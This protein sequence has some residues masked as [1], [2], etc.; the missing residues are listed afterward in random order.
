MRPKPRAFA[1]RAERSPWTLELRTVLAEA[2]RTGD[3]RPIDDLVRRF[4]ADDARRYSS[5][6]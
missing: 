2:E 3:R 5:L 1:E 6:K 4:K